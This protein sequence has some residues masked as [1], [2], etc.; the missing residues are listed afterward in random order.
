[1]MHMH[2]DRSDAES[3]SIPVLGRVALAHA[4]AGRSTRVVAVGAQGF[5]ERTGSALQSADLRILVY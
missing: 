2:H 3:R 4:S 1:M 5:H